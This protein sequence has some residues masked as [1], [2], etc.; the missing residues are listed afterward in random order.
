MTSLRRTVL[1]ASFIFAAA[2]AWQSASR[3]DEG[4]VSFWLPGLFGSLAA[5]P[6][7]PGLSWT[8]LY[9]HTVPEANGSVPLQRG[10]VLAAGINA[11]V[12]AVVFG[13]T[14]TFATPF[15]GAQPALSL[16]GMVGRSEASINATFVT[17]GGIVIPASLHDSRTDFGDL[18]PQATLK[19][20]QG[21]NNVLWYVT[22]DV[23]V[24]AYDSNRLANIGIGHGAIDSG[25]GYTY[26][27]PKAG[28]EFSATTGFTYNFKNPA[29]Q[30]QN[31][32]DWHVDLGASQFLSKQVF[33]G[34]VAY[35]FKQISCDS[36]QPAAIGCF[37][38]RVA[39]AGPQIGFLFPLGGYEAALLIK[40][41]KEFDAKARP[42]GWNLWVALSISPATP[43]PRAPSSLARK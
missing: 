9:Y 27:D 5:V 7:T 28:H 14:Y 15:L 37:E 24:G 20:N 8:T 21:V 42:E 11:K 19:W 4:G 23:P 17:P 10:G 26:F 18:F 12:D 40:G 22:G 2:I 33:V 38:S 6:S 35:Y 30:Y 3:A 43:E 29:T 41:Y 16:L 39:G 1:A 34:A 25:I 13:P 31:G 36:G 32:I